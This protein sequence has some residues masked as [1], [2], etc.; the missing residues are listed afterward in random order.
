[1]RVRK[2][3]EKSEHEQPGE[4]ETDEPRPDH[5]VQDDAVQK[6]RGGLPADDAHPSGATVTSDTTELRR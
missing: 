2:L 1:M 5:A 4:P 3:L 6:V